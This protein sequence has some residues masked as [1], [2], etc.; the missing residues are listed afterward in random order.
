MGGKKNQN[1]LDQMIHSNLKPGVKMRSDQA[2]L[3]AD[4]QLLSNR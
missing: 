1:I 3:E 4:K 2:Y